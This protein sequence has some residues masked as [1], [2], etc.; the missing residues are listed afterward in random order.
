VNIFILSILFDLD[1][2]KFDL[3]KGLTAFVETLMAAMGQL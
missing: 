3:N 1:Y 2:I